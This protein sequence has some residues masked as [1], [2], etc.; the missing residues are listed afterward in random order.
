M[1]HGQITGH[2]P[3]G[4][5]AGNKDIVRVA[6]DINA[7]VAARAA[8]NTSV[9]DDQGIMIVIGA[10]DEGTRV[11]PCGVVHD[12][13]VVTDRRAVTDVPIGITDYATVVDR[14]YVTRCARSTSIFEA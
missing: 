6:A 7:N 9:L 12:T 8:N 3:F 14:Q 10:N 13:G 4:V 11:D 2:I 5:S 1:P